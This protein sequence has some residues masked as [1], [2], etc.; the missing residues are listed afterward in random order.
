VK[1]TERKIEHQNS[2]SG[3]FA[4]FMAAHINARIDEW[5]RLQGDSWSRLREFWQDWIVRFLKV[6]IKIIHIYSRSDLRRY[7]D[8][9]ERNLKNMETELDDLLR[10]PTSDGQARPVTAP[11]KPKRRRSRKNELQDVEV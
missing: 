3:P 8:I 2:E 6:L 11:E 7:Q 9:V 5:Q 4:W 1:S 10:N